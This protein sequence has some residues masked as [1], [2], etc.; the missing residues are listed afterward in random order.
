MRRCQRLV[1]V[2]ALLVLSTSCQGCNFV[3][4]I[5]QVL[6]G[7]ASS[8]TSSAVGGGSAGQM[9]GGAVGGIVTSAVKSRQGSGTGGGTAPARSQGQAEQTNAGVGDNE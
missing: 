3:D 2:L 5:L 7:A 9:L 1:A 4:I 8:G 6:G